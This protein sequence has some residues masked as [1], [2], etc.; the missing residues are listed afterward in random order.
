ML[1][2][3]VGAAVAP[4]T[5][6]FGKLGKTAA[7]GLG[8]IG[9]A[10]GAAGVALFK[11]GEEFDTAY[12]KIRVGTGATGKQLKRLEGDFKAVVKTVPTDF[13]SAST[14]IADLN[15]RLGLTGK[16]L[17]RISRQMLELSRITDTDVRQNVQS[18]TRLFGDWGIKT[19]Q[20]A[21]TMDELFRVSQ[22]T[23]IEIADLSQLMVQFGSPLRQLGFDF[24]TAAVM[25]AKFEKEGVNIQT[26]MPGLRFALKN[27]SGATP[28]LT[29]E[30]KKLGI[31]MNDPSKALREIFALIDKAPSDLKANELAFKVFGQRA[32]PDMAAAIREGRFEYDDLLKTMRKGDDTIRKAGRQTM[33]FSE[34]WQKFKNNVMVALEPLATK[35]FKAIGDEMKTIT[36][37]ISDPKLSKGEKFEA[38]LDHFAEVGQKMIEKAANLGA[39]IGVKL[40]EATGKAFLEGDFL[41]RLFIGGMVLKALGGK[42]AI[43][44]AGR[45]GGKWFGRAWVGGVLLA[46]PLLIPEA[47]KLGKTIGEKIR[48]PLINAMRSA[49][50]WILNAFRNITDKLA[51]V[52]DAI[53]SIPGF[54]DSYDEFADSLRNVTGNVDDLR[55]SLNKT[56]SSVREVVKWFKQGKLS[57]G[58]A[59]KSL[60]DLGVSSKRA[61]T[62]VSKAAAG[63]SKSADRTGKRTVA[64]AKDSG[65][66]FKAVGKISGKTSKDVQGD[67]KQTDKAT[68]RS[69]KDWGKYRSGVGKDMQKVG[70]NA[71]NLADA[72]ADGLGNIQT[73]TNKS[74]KAFGVKELKF[75]IKKAGKSIGNAFK[76]FQP[77]GIL[78]GYSKVDNRL[79]AVRGGEA[80]LRPEDHIPTVSAIMRGDIPPP[81]IGLPEYL[82]RTGGKV[83]F[84]K[85][86]VVPGYAKGGLSFALGPHDIPPIKYDAN[87]AGGNSHWHISG[88]SDGPWIRGIGKALQKMGFS[89]GEHPAFGGVQGSHGH[90]GPSDHYHGGAID[91]NSAADET[92]AESAQVAALLR[93]KGGA[94]AGAMAEKIARVI[95]DGPDGPL[96]DLGQAALDKARKAAQ[97]HLDKQAPEITEMPGG[98]SWKG[99]GKFMS[100]AYGPPWGGIQGT[101]TTYT[102]IDLTSGPKRYI[103]AVDPDVIPLH[104]QL[105]IWPNPHNHRGA[106]AAEDTGGAIKGNRIDFYD[107]R[108]R[109]SQYGWGTRPVNVQGFGLGG[110]V[111]AFAKGGLVGKVK[112]LAGLLPTIGDDKRRKKIERELKQAKQKLK[113]RQKRQQRK[114]MKRLKRQ[115]LLAGMNKKINARQAVVEDLDE[116]IAGLE[117]MHGFTEPR[118]VEEILEKVLRVDPSIDLFRLDPKQRAI[119]TGEINKDYGLEEREL[120]IEKERNEALRDALLSLRAQL[121]E[122]VERA[123]ERKKQVE[124][125]ID[126]TRK[127]EKRESKKVRSTQ[128]EVKKLEKQLADERKKKQPKKLKGAQAKAWKERHQK[129]LAQ[130]QGKI[131]TKR[132]IIGQARTSET[133]LAAQREVLRGN[134][135]EFVAFQEDFESNLVD[136]QGVRGP[137]GTNVKLLPL[138]GGI[139][140]FGG[141][142]RDVNA[143]LYEL[144]VT[145]PEKPKLDFTPEPP[146]ALDIEGLKEFSDAVRLGAFKTDPFGTFAGAFAK[147]GTIPSGMWGIAGE[148]GRPE[149]I[150]GPARVHSPA[151]TERMLSGGSSAPIVIEE[152]HVHP[153]RV[154]LKRDGQWVEAKVHRIIQENEQDRFDLEVAG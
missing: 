4:L 120:D 114:K 96:K 86:G 29:A 65:E 146:Q 154:S 104:S 153:D 7:V 31:S 81:G 110:I 37:I 48:E 145:T 2:K 123:E 35:V 60:S 54:T 92:R 13:D 58:E 68:D 76:G 111:D 18:L 105:K 87:H 122:A 83:G 125:A 12:D 23:G 103:V 147:G 130:I 144:G 42:A 15:T 75:S 80:I 132:V 113:K 88:H 16:P 140:Q 9:V 116:E 127:Q 30:L 22:A 5:S 152:M 64:M 1:Q 102:G 93:G 32:G 84:A 62:I 148:T 95:L 63:M 141:R 25:F 150:E 43:A 143:K 73:N 19:R 33:D 126:R 70:Q 6:K 121:I 36:K 101:G 11:I 91:V 40:A 71:G 56:P 97:S 10:A 79:I 135:G 39:K 149:I 90:Y 47:W 78:S 139:M 134:R 107:W 74:L 45:L 24:D 20:Q 66:G 46:L 27:L 53:P 3:Q 61:D 112:K 77:G 131:A 21:D 57:W 49:F 59:G 108:G 137:K 119:L 151:Q 26:L 85:G 8:A 129:Q 52:Y 117:I 133:M 55:A 89:V 124:K 118:D 128:R 142:L 109:A 14:A 28:E 67:L 72:V 44:G 51:S 94:I 138:P 34:H 100:T 41:T 82:K 106:F 69:K 99:S 115:G 38:L 50:D 17:Q 136:V 98:K